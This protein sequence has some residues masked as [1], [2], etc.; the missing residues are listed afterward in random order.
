MRLIAGDRAPW[1][2]AHGDAVEEHDLEGI[3]AKRKRDPYRRGVHWW[4]IKN[5]AYSQA[6]RRHELFNSDRGHRSRGATACSQVPLCCA[7]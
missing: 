6:E 5:R 4:K 1:L 2:R 7:R 3:V